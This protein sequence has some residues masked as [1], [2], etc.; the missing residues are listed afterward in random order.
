MRA[1][2]VAVIGHV[3]WADFAVV[4]HFPVPGEI[5]HA[6]HF[7]ED[8][9]G[10]GAV[11][12]V[13]LV[14]LAG[15]ASFFTALSSDRLGSEAASRLAGVGLELHVAR[16]AEPQRRAF[17]HLDADAERTISVLGS[18]MVPRGSDDLPWSDLADFDAVYFTGG[19]EEALRAA[20]RARVLVATPR[21]AEILHTAGVELDVLVR[22]GN[23][24]DEAGFDPATM[25]PPPRHVVSTLGSEGGRWIGGEQ[26]GTWKAAAL[27]GPP[28]DAYGCGDSFAAG[29]TY[30]LGAEHSMDEA[31]AL[32]ARC[33]AHCLTGR[34]PYAAQL[35]LTR[36]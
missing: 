36:E 4:D 31:L 24:P 15:T 27:P 16:R 17:V 3:E 1:P 22:S 35:E 7:W 28:V 14:K 33:G 13:Q 9:A 23:D 20:R 11:A 2:R 5:V 10:G 19:D 29:L 25:S 12:A 32:A 18:R 21:A 6:S 30:G 8:A 26:A 34:G